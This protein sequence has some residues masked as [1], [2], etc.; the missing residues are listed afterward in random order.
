MLLSEATPIPLRE[1]GW[2]SRPRHCSEVAS[3][4]FV[5]HR[6]E[7]WARPS[8]FRRRLL[9]RADDTVRGHLLPRA[10][11]SASG[12]ETLALAPSAESEV[13]EEFNCLDVEEVHLRFSAPGYVRGSDV[14]LYARYSGVP[15]GEKLLRI[16]WDYDNDPTSFQDVRLGEGEDRRDSS[17]LF[18]IEH[19]A[20]H[21]YP[22]VNGPVERP[23]RAELILL[24]KSELRAQSPDHVERRGSR[25]GRRLGS[26]QTV[27]RASLLQ[28]R[29]RHRARRGD[30]P[31]RGSRTRI[32]SACADS[33]IATRNVAAPGAASAVSR[34]ARGPETGGFRRSPSSSR[35]S[36][37][38]FRTRA[39]ATPPGTRSGASR[40]LFRTSSARFYWSTDPVAECFLGLPSV[41]VL[42]FANGR[43]AMPVGSVRLRPVLAAARSVRVPSGYSL[44]SGSGVCCKLVV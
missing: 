7:H 15:P 30:G 8:P 14:G 4:L 20:E 22:P 5:P 21:A 34:T 29:R 33:P 18:D 23:V 32:A 12:D 37:R 17:G 24:G 3:C 28:A 2:R 42:N 41:S 27:R 36:T 44:S 16:W 10:H 39:S 6:P 31:R 11:A 40:T 25:R 35:L 1:H 19:L 26:T 13:F 43:R 38:V 9:R